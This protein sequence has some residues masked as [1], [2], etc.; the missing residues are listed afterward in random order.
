MVNHNPIKISFYKYVISVMPCRLLLWKLAVKLILCIVMLTYCRADM[1]FVT[2][3]SD[4]FSAV[5]IGDTEEMH[6][7]T[8]VDG[9][10]GPVVPIIFQDSRG[11]LWFGSKSGGVSRF[12]GQTF[13][14][15]RFKG[16]LSR[17]VTRQIL[18]DRWGHIW[19]L[20][21]LPTEH[22]GV[23]SYFNG[24][25]IE[26]VGVA[27]CMIL[28]NNGDIW[29]ADNRGLTHYTSSVSGAYGQKT[30]VS[31]IGSTYYPLQETTNTTI[32]VLFQSKDGG[33]WIGG[34][35]ADGILLLNFN[36][37]SDPKFIPIRA[38]TTDGTQDEVASTAQHAPAL[39]STDGTFAIHDI[40]QGPYGVEH[41][42]FAGRNLLLRF[43]GKSLYQILPNPQSL[44]Q[45]HP[46]TGNR[47][48]VELHHDA[49]HGHIW[50]CDG[51]SVRWWDGNSLQKLY[52]NDSGELLRAQN[53]PYK[54]S[55]SPDY[56][57]D[58]REF[59]GTLK[60]Q[61]TL[62][63]L[64]FV[65]PT[66]V[67]RH[68]RDFFLRKAYTVEDGLGD[69]NIQTI[70]Q[71][72]DGKIWFGHNNGVTVFRS[73]SAFVNFKTR[74][75]L[76]SNSVRQIYEVQLGHWFS[77]RGGVALCMAGEFFYQQRLRQYADIEIEP[78]TDTLSVEVESAPKPVES[79]EGPP[80]SADPFSEILDAELVESKDKPV[81][82][83]GFF[84]NLGSVWFISSPE[85]ASTEVLYTFFAKKRDSEFKRITIRVRTETGHNSYP[86][87]LISSPEN[88]CI[89][90]G[91]WL[92][93]PD[94]EGLAWLSPDGNSVFKFQES[95][96]FE[97]L[98]QIEHAP[99][100]II[101]MHTD[102]YGKI[103]CYLEDGTVQSYANLNRE[104]I[105][106]VVRP[107]TVPM[108][109][110]K[111]LRLPNP[112][113]TSKGTSENTAP[114]W[115]FNSEKNQIIY[116]DIEKLDEPTAVEGVFNTPP[117]AI[118]ESVDAAET[119]FIFSDHLKKYRGTQLI[120]EESKAEVDIAEVRAALLTGAQVLWIAT[121]QG[122]VRY[123]GTTLT[124][125]GIENGFLVNDLRDVHKDTSG[126]IW[127]ATWGG[128]AVRYDGETFS[129]VTTK[130]GLAHN[131]VS[132]IHQSKDGQIWFATEGGVTRY[133]PMDGALPFCN[134]TAVK[135]DETY[136]DIP[137]TGFAFPSHVNSITF[138]FEG[139]N[140]LRLRHH[141]TYEFKLLGI[142]TND[143]T[144]G[145]TQTP[146]HLLQDTVTQTFATSTP[147][148]TS[149]HRGPSV[150]YHGLKPGNYTFLVKTYRKGWP[151][152]SRP[153][154]VNFTLAT[155]FWA[156]WRSY[157]PYLVIIVLLIVIVP[158]LLARLVMNRRRIARLRAEMQQ[159]EEAE[160]QR[161][162]AELDEA[163]NMQS[164]LL[165]TEPP[166]TEGLDV[167][168][169]SLPATQVGGDFYDYLSI[170]GKHLAIAVADAAGKGLR[171]ALNAV[172]TNGMLNEIAQIQYRADV[173]LT[174]LNASLIPRL[175]GRTFIALN[176][177]I[178]DTESEQML[179]ANA[180]QPYPILKRGETLI[181]IEVS[182]LPLG[183]MKRV[184]YVQEKLELVAGDVLIFYTDGVIEALNSEQEMYDTERLK[185]VI[186]EAPQHL[187][188]EEIVEYI[189]E[190]IQAFVQTAEQYDDIT[191]VV[192]R[193]QPTT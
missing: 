176:L 147:T 40:A 153:T 164:G 92:F 128:G 105:P 124:T 49:F 95:T 126:H 168:G 156:Q 19:F 99:F 109:H 88:P 57:R 111:P 2:H 17:G 180:G 12:D 158:Y 28:D 97:G 69:D 29:T 63:T 67:H 151:Y 108:T 173:I 148:D 122:A 36:R 83:V 119:T 60:M 79:T 77:I 140:P 133:I 114:K 141:L 4:N 50:F 143:W 18:E 46:Q 24:I 149:T 166:Q 87:V 113:V 71:G 121:K 52:R 82:I 189:F 193:H 11:L 134:I 21:R 162:R 135:A 120:P 118:W 30:K 43:D 1:E 98:P 186:A 56:L 172:L 144:R 76:G 159:K 59:F 106:K 39:A 192:V 142:G 38:I 73:Q 90:F 55:V 74:P 96:H 188:A 175:Y 171:G 103:W 25:N 70:F 91:G 45:T 68:P 42:W 154:A 14:Q 54:I 137:E 62:G 182:E 86:E 66:G 139:I 89:A 117:L 13:E 160:T 116:W 20:T 101:D 150:T 100:A 174:N 179:Y 65:S 10:V 107:Q 184:E 104:N 185:S 129:P 178:I 167:A 94:S 136:T 165:P 130:D 15:F 5:G 27:T 22:Q 72:T 9:L 33:F 44:N 47:D 127:F 170:D 37:N 163:R 146:T 26:K 183:S 138:N 8:V 112:R 155:P 41:L 53:G 157:L 78:K 181:D 132:D 32:N 3:I 84:R 7:Y 23:V 75:A 35:T 48:N 191:I 102:R 16:D 61:D 145:S 190:D 169:M 161:I 152:T 123:D 64:W 131:S 58:F 110:I 187:N 6:T 81:E 51:G 125:Y 93:K 177:A 85:Q 34:S 31:T 115:F 80:T